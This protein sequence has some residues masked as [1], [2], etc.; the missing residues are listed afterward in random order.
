MIQDHVKVKRRPFLA[1]IW[2]SVL[3]WLMLV[4][5]LS[6]AAWTWATAG[7]TTV[8]VIRHAEKELN[9]GADPPLTPGGQARAE[10]LSRLLGDSRDPGHIDAIYIAP[11]LRSRMTAAP[12]ASRLGL[13]PIMGPAQ[14]A[15]GIAARLLRE[16]GGGRVLV[17]ARSDTVPE[18]V[19]ALTGAKKLPPIAD[20]EYGEMYIVSVPR[21]GRANFL[22]LNY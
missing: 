17:V 1:P 4:G 16:Q 13:T 22:R 12:L 21:V 14:D 19:E 2:L 11:T 20:D 5:V 9:A 3:G 8:I 7:S 6:W 18:I 10:L 15:R